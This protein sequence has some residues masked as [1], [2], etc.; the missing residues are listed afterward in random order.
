MTTSI[1][2]PELPGDPLGL[3]LLIDIWDRHRGRVRDRV[4]RID[5][6]SSSISDPIGQYRQETTH[7]H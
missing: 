1:A 3:E 7:V 2:I 6:S 5:G 4:E